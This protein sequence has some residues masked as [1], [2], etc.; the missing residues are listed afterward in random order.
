MRVRMQTSGGATAASNTGWAGLIIL[1]FLV[2]A[3]TAPKRKGGR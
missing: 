1:A 3:V 2:L